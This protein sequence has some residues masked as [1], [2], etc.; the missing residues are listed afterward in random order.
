M[1]EKN[2]NEQKKEEA[3]PLC[4]VSEDTIERLKKAEKNRKTED[5]SVKDNGGS[6]NKEQRDQ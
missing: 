6:K 5:K 3:C 1:E 2:K 4:K